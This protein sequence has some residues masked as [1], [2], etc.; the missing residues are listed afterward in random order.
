[1]FGFL[2][3]LSQYLIT[4]KRYQLIVIF[5]VFPVVI[6]LALFLGLVNFFPFNNVMNLVYAKSASLLIFSMAALYLLFRANVVDFWLLRQ[7]ALFI[8]LG[9]TGFIFMP[10][11]LNI[12]VFGSEANPLMLVAF[13]TCLAL[14]VGAFFLFSLLTFSPS[15]SL[16]GEILM[17]FR[18][19]IKVG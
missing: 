1:M 3:V 6:Y 17:A 5:G 7:L 8:T 4:L 16:L 18:S 14:T 10:S 9:L 11:F 13:L 12:G 15:R 19:K 2:N